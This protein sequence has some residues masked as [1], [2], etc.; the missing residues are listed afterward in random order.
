[1]L[2]AESGLELALANVLDDSDDRQVVKRQL[3]AKRAAVGKEQPRSRL[4]DHRAPGRAGAIR[5]RR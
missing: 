4:R 2:G 5:R 1:M 3:P